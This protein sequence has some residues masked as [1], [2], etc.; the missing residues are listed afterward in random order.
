MRLFFCFPIPTEWESSSLAEKRILI[1][2]SGLNDS[3]PNTSKESK[4]GSK[5]KGKLVLPSVPQ[6]LLGLFITV[7]RWL[8]SCYERTGYIFGQQLYLMMSRNFNLTRK[9][10]N[11]KYPSEKFRWIIWLVLN[12]YK[13]IGMDFPHSTIQCF[14][15]GF[16]TILMARYWQFLLLITEKPV[17]IVQARCCAI[18][19]RS[20]TWNGF[21]RNKR[22][23]PSRDLLSERAVDPSPA[24]SGGG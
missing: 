7:S 18:R 15:G 8:T 1:R 20:A 11:R 3:I 4:R 16:H 12:I 13:N 17:G 22:I 6:P 5:K 21:S 2:A 19:K 23:I 14:L 9:R 10:P 24:F